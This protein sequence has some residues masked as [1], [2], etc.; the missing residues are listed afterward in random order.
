MCMLHWHICYQLKRYNTLFFYLIH[1]SGNHAWFEKR[2]LPWPCLSLSRS[3][4]V[5]SQFG[6][7]L[8]LDSD[9]MQVR[10]YVLHMY[11]DTLQHASVSMYTVQESWHRPGT[12]CQ[13]A[14]SGY[15]NSRRYLRLPFCVLG[16]GNSD[17]WKRCPCGAMGEKTVSLG[18]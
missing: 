1:Q 14:M 6:V 5:L 8:A 17:G 3:L 9:C 11:I 18:Q 16:K 15:I 10:T 2:S 12:L 13:T 4:P 7:V